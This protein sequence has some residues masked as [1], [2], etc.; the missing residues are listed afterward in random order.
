MTDENYGKLCYALGSQL[1]ETAELRKYPDIIAQAKS[2]YNQVPQ[3][4][5]FYRNAMS[6]FFNLEHGLDW[7][8]QLR[9]ETQSTEAR[10]DK[11]WGLLDAFF[12][13]KGIESGHEALDTHNEL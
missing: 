11:L 5:T 3:T 13:E 9:D 6:E 12:K 2:Y 8:E 7:A 4:S 1:Y 10:E